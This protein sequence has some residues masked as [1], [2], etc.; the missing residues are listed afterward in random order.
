MKIL[1]STDKYK[2]N[3]VTWLR[4]RL[5]S[6]PY[7]L[8]TLKDKETIINSYKPVTGSGAMSKDGVWFTRNGKRVFSGHVALVVKIRGDIIT[9]HEANYSTCKV[10]ER[11]GTM[12]QLNIIG[13]FVPNHL[14]T[15]PME[16]VYRANSELRSATESITGKEYG[17]M[18][19]DKLQKEAAEDLE[20]AT[21]KWN[22]FNKVYHKLVNKHKEL[23]GIMKM[24]KK[25]NDDMK[26]TIIIQK[27]SIQ[28]F[29]KEK[30][31]EQGLKEVNSFSL[32][33]WLIKIFTK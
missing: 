6:L 26:K 10:T 31:D 17:K 27:E 24:L 22:D 4:Q 9:I 7:G 15:K 14:I 21:E 3:C 20:E 29:E 28:E 23:A 33:K 18:D 30:A 11:E 19:S 16:K 2:C 12:S 25:E 8:W 1:N 32:G 5:P 13:F